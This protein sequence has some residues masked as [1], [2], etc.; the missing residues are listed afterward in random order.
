M[1]LGA[2]VGGIGALTKTFMSP[3]AATASEVGTAYASQLISPPDPPITEPEK[4]QHLPPPGPVYIDSSW[5]NTLHIFATF[6]SFTALAIG[7]GV[8]L[9]IGAGACIGKRRREATDENSESDD[10]RLTDEDDPEQQLKD[11]IIQRI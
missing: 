10:S 6:A 8:V 11:E 4:L 1:P 7:F 9:G 5:S 3:F 2:A